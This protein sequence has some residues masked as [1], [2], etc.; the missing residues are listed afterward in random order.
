MK[1]YIGFTMVCAF[2]YFFYLWTMLLPEIM[3]YSHITREIF[4]N[5]F[6]FIGAFARL[7]FDILAGF[8]INT[9][10]SSEYENIYVIKVFV[11]SNTVFVK[12]YLN[13]L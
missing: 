2:T 8:L 7:F 9:K 1:E 5:K 3:I 6:Y 10:N 11:I 13:L 4:G 12:N